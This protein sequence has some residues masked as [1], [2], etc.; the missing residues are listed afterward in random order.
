MEEYTVMTS[1]VIRW[2]S[3]F[4]LFVYIGL[5]CFEN[6][7]TSIIICGILAQVR[8]TVLACVWFNLHV[9]TGVSF[10]PA[11]FLPLLLRLLSFLH[12]CCD[13]GEEISPDLVIFNCLLQVVVNHYLAFKHFGEYY[14]PFSEVWH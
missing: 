5:F 13:H 7:P 1:K 14:Y 11:G 10:R 8:L 9:L 3:V 12:Q 2:M 4:C 6:L